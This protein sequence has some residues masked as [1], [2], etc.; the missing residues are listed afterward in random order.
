MS[1]DDRLVASVKRHE[2]Y[3]QFAYHCSEGALTIG[4][5]TVIEDGGPGISQDVAELLL[6]NELEVV[7]QKFNQEYWFHLLNRTQKN[8][9]VEM[10]YQ[11]GFNGVLKFKKMIAA[12][13]VKDFDSAHYEALDSKWARQTPSRAK[14]VAAGLLI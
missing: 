1:V 2:G 6:I 13:Q 4:Y 7:E 14:E 9:I 3:R 8:A 10:G 12:I 11:L 5:G